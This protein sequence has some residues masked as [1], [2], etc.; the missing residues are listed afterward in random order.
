MDSLR[1]A[2]ILPCYNEEA[3]IA[4]TVAGFRAAL[5]AA[6]IYVYDNNSR[7]RTAEIARAC[8]RRRPDRAAAG[9]GPC[10]PPDVRRHRCRRICHGRRRPDLRSRSRRRK[11]CGCWST[12]SS[13]W[14]SGPA[15]T[16]RRMPIAAAMSSAIGCS[17]GCWP[18]CSAAA[19]P[20]SFP[21]IASFRGGSS[22]ASR[23]SSQGFEIETEIS[24]HALELRMPVGEAGDGLWRSPRRL[25]IETVDLS[26]WLADPE[27]DRH[28]LPD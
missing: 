2:V 26:R 19:S 14:W 18:A 25:G 4:E 3:A 22:K 6:A 15:S 8:R 27:N 20:I 9:Q 16:R 13:T 21:A 28:A 5:P 23:C 10:R 17:P 12:I 11:W 24:V 7:D 1:I